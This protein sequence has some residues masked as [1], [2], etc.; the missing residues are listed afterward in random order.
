MTQIFY[1]IY[2]FFIIGHLTW[3]TNFL[4]IKNLKNYIKIYLITFTIVNITMLLYLLLNYNSINNGNNMYN[5][6]FSIFDGLFF[7]YILITTYTSCL[8]ILKNNK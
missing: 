4:K 1:L 8:E 6:R 2:S 3:F 5:I 7:T